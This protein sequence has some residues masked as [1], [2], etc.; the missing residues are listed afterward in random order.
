LIKKVAPVQ[1]FPAKAR[2]RNGGFPSSADSL[3]LEER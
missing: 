3:V 1:Y 2:I